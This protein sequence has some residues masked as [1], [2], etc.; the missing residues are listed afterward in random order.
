M[1]VDHIFRNGFIVD[2]TGSPGFE[3]DVAV[4][5]GLIHAIGPDLQLA[6]DHEEDCT[7]LIITPGFIDIHTH[8]DGQVTWDP[9]LEASSA[10]GVTTCVIGTC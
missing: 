4:K 3:G 7:G 1:S 10:N 8:Y 6:A 9:I 2:G 5:D